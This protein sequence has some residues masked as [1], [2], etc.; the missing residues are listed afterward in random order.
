M[1]TITTT[2]DTFYNTFPSAPCDMIYPILPMTD[3]FLTY[4]TFTS[5]PPPTTTTTTTP[6]LYN[7]SFNPVYTHHD[8]LLNYNSKRKT[9]NDQTD[10]AS[11]SPLSSTSYSSSSSFPEEKTRAPPI[12][13]PRKSKES[14]LS[15]SNGDESESAEDEE[16]LRQKSLERNRLAAYKCRQRKKEWIEELAHKAERMTKENENLKQLLFQLK[17]EAVYIKSQLIMHKEN[18]YDSCKNKAF[19]NVY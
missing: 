11:W 19:L 9:M 13:R 8:E 5:P 6:H 17:E 1:D 15:T 10:P 12:K 14:K 2:V 3:P 16:E 18:D 4:S 7:N